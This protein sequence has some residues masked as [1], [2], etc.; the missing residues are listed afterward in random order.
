MSGTKTESSGT[1]CANYFAKQFLAVVAGIAK[2]FDRYDTGSIESLQLRY[3]AFYSNV[4]VSDV[5]IHRAD[6]S[7]SNC[8]TSCLDALIK[9]KKERKTTKRS[10]AIKQFYWTILSSMLLFHVIVPCYCRH[11]RLSLTVQWNNRSN[12]AVFNCVVTDIA[13]WSLKCCFLN[14]EST[15]RTDLFLIILIMN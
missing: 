14:Y 2:S 5:A 13:N 11:R 9:K 6:G 12:F 4:A 8:L 7:M 3:N 15:L 1:T 10:F